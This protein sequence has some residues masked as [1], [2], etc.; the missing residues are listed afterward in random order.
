M[1]KGVLY[2]LALLLSLFLVMALLEHFGY[3]GTTVRAILFWCYLLFGVGIV[4][5][6]VAVPLGKIFRL[7]KVISYQDAAKIIGRHFPDVQDKLLNLL[8]LQ[9]QGESVHDDLLESA[10]AQ[11]TLL[12]KPVPFL[13]AIDLK[14]NTKYLKYVAVPTLVILLLM[15][16][17]P[18][19]ITGPSHRITHY[20]NLDHLLGTTPK[21]T[22]DIRNNIAGMKAQ[23]SAIDRGW[24]LNE[25]PVFDYLGAVNLYSR[26]R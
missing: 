7:G 11:K 19:M 5:Y 6:Y 10:I 1:I 14:A 9:E 21:N 26:E 25:L 23:V 18:T 13:Q 15:L 2:T 22:R 3:F 24:G 8:Q 20:N 4:A 16:V 17:S 12:L